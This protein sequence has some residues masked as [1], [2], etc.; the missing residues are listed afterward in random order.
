MPKTS[1][2]RNL[3]LCLDNYPI[4]RL[5]IR[6]IGSMGGEVKVNEILKGR[7]LDFKMRKS[8]LSL[9]STL[10]KYFVFHL[11]LIA[12]DFLLPTNGFVRPTME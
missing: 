3:R 12:R 2:Q 9:T 11:S 1:D 5:F 7:K 4:D 8:G 10:W 6:Q